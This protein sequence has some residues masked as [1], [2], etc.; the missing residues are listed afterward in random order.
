MDAAVNLEAHRPALTGHCYRMLGSVTEAD[1]AVQE[2]MLRAWKGLDDFAARSQLS[3]WLHR[4]ATNVCLDSLK[5]RSRRELPVLDGPSGSP[6]DELVAHPATHWLEP[7]PD[8]HCLPNV[9]APEREAVQRQYL[10]LAFVAA[11]QHLPPR[12]RAA[13]LLKDVV[14][15]STSEIS[16]TLDWPT[17]GVNSALQRARKTMSDRQ[18]V[19]LAPATLSEAQRDLVD[20]YVDAFHRY[21]V[22]SLVSLLRED[23]TMSMP[24]FTLW[25]RGPEAVAGFMLGPGAACRDSRLV[26]TSASGTV[27]FAHYKNTDGTYRAW[28]L[29]VLDLDDQA[30]RGVVH[31]LDVETL[32]PRFGFDLELPN[33]AS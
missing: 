29:I 26:P 17:A 28:S 16:S 14:G 10:K 2:T 9:G 25:L 6:D 12:Q 18:S 5:S 13:L 15:F 30:L 3:T 27:A 23:G 4:I 22:E 21:D 32:F 1:D 31:F 24:P 19:P 20:R 33:D 8:A 7:I 11:L